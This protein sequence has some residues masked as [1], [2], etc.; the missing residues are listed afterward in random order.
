MPIQK[1]PNTK[2]FYLHVDHIIENL[3]NLPVGKKG[4]Q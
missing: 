3:F 2:K 4:E 1:P